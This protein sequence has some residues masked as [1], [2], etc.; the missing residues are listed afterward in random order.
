MIMCV[1][2]KQGNNR[3]SPALKESTPSTPWSASPPQHSCW[4]WRGQTT[5]EDPRCT[6]EQGCQG[7]KFENEILEKFI[8][9]E[10]IGSIWGFHPLHQLL[11]AH[12]LQVVQSVPTNDRRSTNQPL[13]MLR[14]VKVS[15]VCR[16][17]ELHYRDILEVCHLKINSINL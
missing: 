3:P 10:N 13:C 12:V 7:T 11:L 14:L 6:C 4:S 16:L 8:Q 2:N 1:K 17:E 9:P 5:W 15:P